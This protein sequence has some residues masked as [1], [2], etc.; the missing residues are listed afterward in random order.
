M[1][2]LSVPVVHMLNSQWC[3]AICVTILL[4]ASLPFDLF[5]I[6]PFAGITILQLAVFTANLPAGRQG[7]EDAK[8][9]FS[10]FRKP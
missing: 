1:N 6:L 8:K 9:K 7:R 2:I 4:I 10:N 3:Q 5:C